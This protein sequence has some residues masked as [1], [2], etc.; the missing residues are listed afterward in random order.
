M[1]EFQ[2]N[3][4]RDCINYRERSI[5]DEKMRNFENNKIVRFAD[6]VNSGMYKKTLIHDLETHDFKVLAQLDVQQKADK[7]FMEPIL[8][9][10]KNEYDTY[11]AYK[12][13]GPSLQNNMEL[14]KKI[15]KVEPELIKDTPISDNKQ[16]IM[17]AATINSKVIK[18]MSQELKNDMEIITELYKLNDAAV[19]RGL[20]EEPDMLSLVLTDEKFCNDRVFMDMAIEKNVS[21]LRFASEELKNDYEF[22]KEQSS[23]NEEVIEQVIH[24]ANEF[25]LEGIKAT[26]DTSR[27]FTIE[28][29]MKII[30][31]MS[32]SSD[33]KR[34]QKVK[35]KIKERGVDDVH[36]VR[37]I[38]AMVAQGDNID[39]KLVKK[40]L[41]YS[42]LNMEKTQRDL[43]G[44]GEMKVSIDNMQE[45]VTPYILNQLQEKV[46]EQGLEINEDIS[47][48]LEEYNTFYQGFDDKLRDYKS[49]KLE[50]KGAKGMKEKTTNVST[51]EEMHDNDEFKKTCQELSHIYNDKVPVE[52][53]Q[54]EDSFVKFTQLLCKKTFD[55]GA[56][57]RVM[58]IDSEEIAGSYSGFLDFKIN[59]SQIKA[60]QEGKPLEVFETICHELHHMGQKKDWE[61]VNVKNSIMEKDSYLKENVE[62]YYASNYDLVASEVDAHLMQRE[63]AINI[64][65]NLEIEPTGEELLISQKRHDEFVKRG[66]TTS[67][68]VGNEVRDVNE[69]FQETLQ[70]KMGEMDEYDLDTFM[71]GKPCTDIEYKRVDNKFVRRTPDELEQIYAKWQDGNLKLKGEPKQIDMYFQYVKDD[72]MKD[73]KNLKDEEKREIPDEEKQSITLLDI[74]G[75]TS[76]TNVSEINEETRVVKDEIE[77]ERQ[78]DQ[79]LEEK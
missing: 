52:S 36:A 70:K 58:V 71:E 75:A 69:L 19:L 28:D 60:F 18:Y 64:L 30:D 59:R 4:K 29:G 13:Y 17:E 78:A 50:Q 45:L 46:R 15:I 47:K 65:K 12:Y 37:W 56:N 23:K 27:E 20:V 76:Q 67:R 74:E 61:N 7:D 21:V 39:P 25:G 31:E 51:I 42:V 5:R 11:V 26:R 6:L 55:I 53:K 72:K 16:F 10:I 57:P 43:M 77:P 40:V 66:L 38:T 63:N 22:I 73:I 24:N 14:A 33:D 54:L 48:K 44:N 2:L 32:A 9:A 68:N 62:D 8:Y 79:E 3:N 1:L 34:Y 49:N 35:D 41:N